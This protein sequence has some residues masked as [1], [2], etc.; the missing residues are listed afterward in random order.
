M[1]LVKNLEATFSGFDVAKFINSHCRSARDMPSSGL[2]IDGLILVNQIQRGMMYLKFKE[3]FMITNLL[4]RSFES[5]QY[6][7]VHVHWLI[8][9]RFSDGVYVVEGW[10][11]DDRSFRVKV[12]WCV[13]DLVTEGTIRFI[14]ARPIK[15]GDTEFKWEQAEHEKKTIQFVRELIGHAS[16][17]D[18]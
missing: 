16:P 18:H 12:D 4:E 15:F 10:Q 5:P 9:F 2:N 7:I 11:N 6:D 1:R 8:H 13:I 14:N 3:G 17:P